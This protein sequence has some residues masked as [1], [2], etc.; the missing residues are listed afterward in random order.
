[1]SQTPRVRF[2]PSPTGELHL[3]G[4]RTALFNFLFAKQNGG[5]F[6]LRIEDTDEVRSREK[7]VDQ[8]CDSL[9][10]LGLHW[11]GP[12]LYQSR[13]KD[14]YRAAVK[15]LLN[16]G[17][18]YRCFCTKEEL[19][20]ER[21][22]AEKEEG[23][24][25]YSGKCSQLSDSEIKGKLNAAELFCI[26][27]KVT[28]EGRTPFDDEV[29]GTVDVDNREIDDFIIQRTDGS[30]TY[31]FVVVVDD[32]D[33]E[34]THVIRGEDHLTNTSKQIKVYEALDKRI[35]KFAH[36]PMILGLDGK[37]LSKRH[38]AVG[39]QTYRDRGYLPEALVNFLALL[40]WNP[41]DV[42]EIFSLDELIQE[43]SLSRIIKK[44]AV[45]DDKK[46]E[47]M[48]GQHIMATPANDLL[49]RIRE[50]DPNWK[51]DAIP[52]FLLTI[53]EVQQKRM[54]TLVD[55]MTQSDYFFDAP[56]DYDFK[57]ALKRWGDESVN[58]LMKKFLGKLEEVGEWSEERIEETLR[59]LAQSKELSPGKLI[60][61]TRLALTGVPHGP[62]LFLLME[63]LGEEVCVQR[64]QTALEKL[65]LEVREVI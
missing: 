35:P 14:E 60:H 12:L 44:A 33:M 56:E 51:N 9:R 48:S 39:V 26:R 17:K 59:D 24:Y 55:I 25:G 64:I 28:D 54:K 10:W 45:F 38:G 20:E 49:E 11:D 47:W 40:G 37:R 8:I 50:L 32:V 42:Q 34:I 61:P 16:E 57:T 13:R 46:F 52:D 53:V 22:K 15:K 58:V 1:M 62:S 36:L 43:F 3:G 2:A 7:Y 4:A 65:P 23:F 21:R 19:A 63:M 18:A 6:C 30:P 31:N 27:L 41:G 5:K 29:Y